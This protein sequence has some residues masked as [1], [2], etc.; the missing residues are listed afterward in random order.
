MSDYLP[1]DGDLHILE[2]KIAFIAMA[3]SAIGML[4]AGD[5][6]V[7]ESQKAWEGLGWFSSE[8]EENLRAINRNISASESL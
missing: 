6:E 5:Y 7:L 3:A 8:L 1:I 4:H 2:S